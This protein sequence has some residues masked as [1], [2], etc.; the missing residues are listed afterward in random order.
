MINIVIKDSDTL[1]QRGLTFFFSDFFFHSNTKV[2][3]NFSFTAES[4]KVADVIVLALCPG[5]YF[6]CC[7]VLQARKKGVVI[8]FVDDNIRVSALPA[9]FQDIIFVSRRAS[10]KQL[11][12]AL[13][14]AL[15]RIQKENYRQSPVSCLDCQ[16]K[17]LSP[18][19]IRIMIG[20]Y[21]GMSVMQIADE[22]MISEKTVFAHKYIARQKF[23]LR[24]DY[25]LILLLNKM[26]ESQ[27]WS[28]FLLRI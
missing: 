12:T 7:P 1:F 2:D 24:S 19:Q 3:F 5:E 6:I 21:K 8:G 27:D 18:Q 22:L 10:L 17:K 11:R 16:P 25:E 15:H 20:L 26:A 23:N 13:H 28:N 4:V 14:A 9:C